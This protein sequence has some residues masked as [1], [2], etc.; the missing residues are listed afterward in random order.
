MPFRRSTFHL[1]FRLDPCLFNLFLPLCCCCATVLLPRP[2]T[3]MTD[4]ASLY[5]AEAA[6][7]AEAQNPT[8]TKPARR[9]HEP[10]VSP[11]FGASAALKRR[12]SRLNGVVDGN[13]G[14]ERPA[15]TFHGTGNTNP[16]AA[17]LYTVSAAGAADSGGMLV[18][19]PSALS[20]SLLLGK[21]LDVADAA[22]LS[23]VGSAAATPLNPIAG[24]NGSQYQPKTDKVPPPQVSRNQVEAKGTLKSPL[25]SPQDISPL[26]TEAACTWGQELGTILGQEVL[27]PA[28]TK[29]RMEIMSLAGRPALTTTGLFPQMMTLRYSISTLFY[30]CCMILRM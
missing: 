21:R 18:A 15:A 13:D 26:V 12:S 2:L 27:H 22:C 29:P 14:G 9:L 23:V 1:P 4:P 28:T 24:L 5:R 17:P 16:Q 25:T 6:E 3:V 20:D 10:F 8:P 11:E 19:P 30:C 7:A